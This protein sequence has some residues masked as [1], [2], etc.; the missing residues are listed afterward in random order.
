MCDA[1]NGRAELSREFVR[2]EEGNI[3]IRVKEGWSLNYLQLQ[4]AKKNLAYCFNFQKVGHVSS[5]TVMLLAGIF[6][7]L[8]FTT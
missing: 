4:E 2:V 3:L 6:N 8:N 7:L 5:L 1:F